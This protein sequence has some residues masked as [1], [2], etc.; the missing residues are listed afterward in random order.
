MEQYINGSMIQQIRDG[1]LAWVLFAPGARE[2]GSALAEC[3]DGR[4]QAVQALARINESRV[5]SGLAKIH[6]A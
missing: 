4:E 6:A 2:S 5:A 1:A 3:H